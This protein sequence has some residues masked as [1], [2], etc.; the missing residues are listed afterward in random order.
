MLILESPEIKNL[1]KSY[2]YL[3]SPLYK[4]FNDYS[5]R[6]LAKNTGPVKK[7]DGKGDAEEPFDVFLSHNSK[8]EAIVIQLAEKLK[9]YGLRVWLDVW[10]LVPGQSWQEA[11]EEIIQSTKSAA[12]LVGKDGMGPWEIQEMRACL[13]EFIKRK[14]P[15]IPVLLPGTPKKPE[16]PLFLRLFQWVDLRDGLTKDGID[17]LVW[18]ITGKRP[19]RKTDTEKTNALFG[20]V[21][22][23]LAQINDLRSNRLID[24]KIALKYQSKLL[25]RLIEKEK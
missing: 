7:N 19:V 4:L 25:D 12:I 18:G 9:E 23:K 22:E 15:T 17:Q 10:E 21:K 24:D 13:Y 14:Q 5:D 8:D 2:F 6:L 16:L 1:C 3:I 11:L 20:G